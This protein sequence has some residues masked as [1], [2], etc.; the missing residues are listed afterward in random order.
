MLDVQN[1]DG[2]WEQSGT[3]DPAYLTVLVLDALNLANENPGPLTFRMTATAVPA[4]DLPDLSPA[5]VENVSVRSDTAELRKAAVDAY[6]D[7]VFERKGIRIRRVD[8]WQAAK[9]KDP[10]EFQRWQRKDSRTT[11]AAEQAF[12]RILSQKPHLK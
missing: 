6:I 8:I 11:P 3:P 10:T 1:E 4:P 2:Y 7:E 12:R 5:K 9:Y